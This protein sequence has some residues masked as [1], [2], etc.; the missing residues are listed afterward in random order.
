MLAARLDRTEK[1]VQDKVASLRAL[2]SELSRKEGAFQTLLEIEKLDR[3]EALDQVQE[4]KTKNDSLLTELAQKNRRTQE[5]A[6]R[7]AAVEFPS[8][9]RE[10]EMEALKM[11]IVEL[12]EA[13]KRLIERTATISHRY[14]NNDLV[15]FHFPC[16]S[17]MTA[18]TRNRMTTR[19]PWLLY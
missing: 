7:L 15:N 19:R 13:E 8:T 14:E 9:E 10:R 12:E 6:E 16:C 5:L 4:A 18:A 11:R 17:S 1:E 3:K 2:E